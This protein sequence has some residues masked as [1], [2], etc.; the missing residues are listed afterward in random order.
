MVAQLWS[1]S[2]GRFT[3]FQQLAELS[4]ASVRPSGCGGAGWRVTC[5]PAVRPTH[6]LLLATTAL[7]SAGWQQQAQTSPGVVSVEVS[8]SIECTG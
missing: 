8:P 3:S 6:A 7:N 2:S 5:R 4:G 1:K